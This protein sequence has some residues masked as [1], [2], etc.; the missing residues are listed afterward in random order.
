MSS[1]SL[2]G[3]DTRLQAPDK[4]APT[5]P[6]RHW[7]KAVHYAAELENGMSPLSRHSIIAAREEGGGQARRRGPAQGFCVVEARALS[8]LHVMQRLPVSQ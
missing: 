6:S 7:P 8:T 5:Y 1:E 3:I 4:I 2:R